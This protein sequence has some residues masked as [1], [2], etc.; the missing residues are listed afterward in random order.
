MWIILCS[1]SAGIVEV[2]GTFEG[3]EQAFN[4]G[5]AE[6]GGASFWLVV[7]LKSPR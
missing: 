7:R 1:T 2:I 6:I 5:E 4:W 3:L